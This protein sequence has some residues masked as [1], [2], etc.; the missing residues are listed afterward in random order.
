MLKIGISKSY[1]I[2]ITNQ[3]KKTE[4]GGWHSKSVN[5]DGRL[6]LAGVGKRNT[7]RM[8]YKKTNIFSNKTH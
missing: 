5:Y 6:D 4:P 2:K 3:V 1:N 8:F 7:I